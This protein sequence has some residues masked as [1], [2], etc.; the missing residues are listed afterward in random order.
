MEGAV[1]NDGISHLA[2]FVLGD[3]MLAFGFDVRV[4]NLHLF[5]GFALAHWLAYFWVVKGVEFTQ[6][7]AIGHDPFIS[8]KNMQP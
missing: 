4:V 7:S 5:D 2:A 6:V 8:F 1:V 3:R